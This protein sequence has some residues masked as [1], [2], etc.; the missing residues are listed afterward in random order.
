MLTLIL[1]LIFKGRKIANLL[2]KIKGYRASFQIQ[3]SHTS[4]LYYYTCSKVIKKKSKQLFKEFSEVIKMQQ[5]MLNLFSFSMLISF[6]LQYLQ[7]TLGVFLRMVLDSNDDC[8]VSIC[9]KIL[10]LN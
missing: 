6:F 1:K 7:D 5:L 9:E 10:L 8:E 2:Q 4:V 3:R